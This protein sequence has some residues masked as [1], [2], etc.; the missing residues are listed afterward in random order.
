MGSRRSVGGAVDTPKVTRTVPSE[1]DNNKTPTTTTAHATSINATNADF[2][3]DATVRRPSS[4]PVPNAGEAY[5]PGDRALVSPWRG[6]GAEPRRRTLA[7]AVRGVLG[8]EGGL[9]NLRQSLHEDDKVS[10]PT[11]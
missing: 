4:A 3:R 9:E 11:C 6:A 10:A 5:L 1:T 7:N 8:V 2:I